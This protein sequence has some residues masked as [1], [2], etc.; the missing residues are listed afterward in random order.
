MLQTCYLNSFFQISV[1]MSVEFE[2]LHK[3]R[4]SNDDNTAMVDFT[5]EEGYGKYLDLHHAY[6][7]Y[8]NIKGE[9]QLEIILMGDA[10]DLIAVT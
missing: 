9:G 8:C 4:E 7:K 5:D 6:N 3:L 2:E 1:P 10:L